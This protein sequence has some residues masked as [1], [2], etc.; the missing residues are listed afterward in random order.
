M[1][2]SKVHCISEMASSSSSSESVCCSSSDETNSKRESL[3]VWMKS[4]VMQGNGCTV[5]NENGA[6]VYRMDNYDTKRSKK[7]YLMDFNGKVIFTILKKVINSVPWSIDFMCSIESTNYIVRV[8]NLT[9][10]LMQKL[11]LFRSWEGYKSSSNN[12]NIWFRVK[13]SHCILKKK[14][15]CKITVFSGKIERGCCSI[16]GYPGNFTIRNN[17]GKLVAQVSIF[18]LRI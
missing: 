10:L 8:R 18:M 17:I 11:R 3:T 2:S 7:V 13:K 14:S 9:V 16:E 6:V 1:A 15:F 5:F 12:D 4:L